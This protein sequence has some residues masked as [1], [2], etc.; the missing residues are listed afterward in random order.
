MPGVSDPIEVD[1]LDKQLV[2][3]FPVFNPPI[4]AGVI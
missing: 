3:F 2:R 1:D 4:Q